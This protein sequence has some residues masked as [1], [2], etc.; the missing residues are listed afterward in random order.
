MAWKAIKSSPLFSEDNQF[1]E[2]LMSLSGT[3]IFYEGNQ[4]LN[5]LDLPSLASNSNL[6]QA[7]V[8]G[9][10]SII[11]RCDTYTINGCLRPKPAS[12]S[13]KTEKS[14]GYK[15]TKILNEIVNRMENNEELTSAHIALLNSTSIP[16]Y[17][18]LNV[19][20]TYAPAT[21]MM[22]I[23]HYAEL[24][25]YDLLYHFLVEN[26]KNVEQLSR[27]Q[28]DI[29]NIGQDFFIE[30]QKAR[31]QVDRERARTAEQAN[32]V[33]SLIE[34]AKNVEKELAGQFSSSMRNSIG[35][36]HE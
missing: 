14:L 3:L 21:K 11:Y 15:V 16:V 13:I 4:N 28:L 10:D 18:I 30:M 19:Y 5:M 24:I 36:A 7:L 26:I 34:K 17:R 9:G 2:F 12:I 1:A 33:L 6:I 35:K 8:Y 27:A 22:D 29:G 32:H 31:E 20:T 23:Q 25:A